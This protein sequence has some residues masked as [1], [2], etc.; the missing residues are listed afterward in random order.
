MA[1]EDRTL[2][3]IAGD[4]GIPLTTAWRLARTLEMRDFL[5]QGARGHYHAGP[6]LLAMTDRISAQKTVAGVARP[7]LARLARRFRCVAHF[8]VLEQDMVTYLVRES[9][10]PSSVPTKQGSQLEAYCSAIGK[11]LLADL[12][13][14]VRKD[15]LG[16][17]P[18]I[19]L[20]ERTITNR[21]RLSAELDHIVSVGFAIDEREVRDDLIC[22]AVAVRDHDSN[23]FGAISLADVRTDSRLSDQALRLDCLR[24]AAEDIS[25]RLGHLTA[26]SGFVVPC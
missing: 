16:S 26:R 15:Y 25:Q 20:T 3:D 4:V 14:E 18:L 21:N 2:Q 24:G 8:G 9:S 11:V 12:G 6:A 19:A 7:I 17:G 10:A 23:A 22:L 5:L 13:P 1:G